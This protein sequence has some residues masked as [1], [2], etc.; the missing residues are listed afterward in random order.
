MNPSPFFLSLLALFYL[1]V[2]LNQLE[3]C[4]LNLCLGYC[5]LTSLIF[6]VNKISLLSVLFYCGRSV[7]LLQ[8][9]G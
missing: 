3:Y 9:L 4:L 2:T 6:E 7:A 1:R 5:K 8:F